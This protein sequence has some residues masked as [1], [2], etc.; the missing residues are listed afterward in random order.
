MRTMQAAVCMLACLDENGP[1]EEQDM[2]CE[3]V[4]TA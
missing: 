4:Q 2:T 1:V 3:D